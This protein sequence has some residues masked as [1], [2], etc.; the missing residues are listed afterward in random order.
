MQLACRTGP[1]P[2]AQPHDR[3]VRKN[4]GLPL[5]QLAIALAAMLTIRATRAVL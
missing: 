3:S 1:D 5:L 2:A 4:E